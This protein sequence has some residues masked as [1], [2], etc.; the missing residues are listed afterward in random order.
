M[1]LKLLVVSILALLSLV[2][3]QKYSEYTALKSIN[4]YESC[5][6]AKGSTIQES[7]PATCLTRLGARFTQPAA[8]IPIA[9]IPSD[10]KEIVLPNWSFFAP[11]DWYVSNCQEKYFVVDSDNK[12]DNNECPIDGDLY[13]ARQSRDQV[14]EAG[15]KKYLD[16]PNTRVITTDILIDDKKATKQTLYLPGNMVEGPRIYVEFPTYIDSIA[17]NTENEGVITEILSTFKFTN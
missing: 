9:P 1:K 17:Y 15:Y 7:Y 11:P 5:A 10:W 16:L 8:V 3:Y 12:S 6:S 13:L 14:P 2:A 4:S